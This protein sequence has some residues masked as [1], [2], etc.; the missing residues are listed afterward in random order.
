LLPLAIFF[1][2]M[3]LLA[4]FMSSTCSITEICRYRIP[5]LIC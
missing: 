2:Q 4:I 3:P 1:K 5:T